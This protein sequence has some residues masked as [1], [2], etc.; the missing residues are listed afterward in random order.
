MSSSSSS[1]LLEANIEM[2]EQQCQEIQW[3][4]KEEQKLQTY[5]EEIA[6]AHYLEWAV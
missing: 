5:L 1:N 6:E 3:W 2:L 4:Y